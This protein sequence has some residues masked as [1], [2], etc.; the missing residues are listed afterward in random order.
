MAPLLIRTAAHFLPN[1]K[2]HSGLAVRPFCQYL[3]VFT[4]ARVFWGCT[5][6][7]PGYQ[8]VCLQLAQTSLCQV[9][10]GQEGQNSHI[11]LLPHDSVFLPAWRMPVPST[12]ICG[13]HCGQELLVIPA[14]K[15]MYQ[16]DGCTTRSHSVFC[17]GKPQGH[18]TSSLHTEAPEIWGYRGGGHLRSSL[19]L[20]QLEW[21]PGTPPSPQVSKSRVWALLVAVSLLGLLSGNKLAK[22]T[23]HLDWNG[24]VTGLTHVVMPP[25]QL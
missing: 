3:R 1:G 12:Q 11:Q 7:S 18:Q 23:H 14:T 19:A 4:Y 6:R 20:G 5:A 25:G 9:T 16:G 24:W 2:T 21:S 13:D 10:S 8:T 15:S 22:V 17:M